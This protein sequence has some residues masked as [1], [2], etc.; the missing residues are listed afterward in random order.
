MSRRF[1]CP[2]LYVLGDVITPPGIGLVIEDSDMPVI[3]IID[4]DMLD[5]I[6]VV[7]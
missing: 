2:C 5:K 3:A 4:N 7:K 6:P 1:T